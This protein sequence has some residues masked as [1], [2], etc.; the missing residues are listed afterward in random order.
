L[1]R[2]T[3]AKSYA[4]Q[5]KLLRSIDLEFEGSDFEFLEKNQVMHFFQIEEVLKK[6]LLS[7]GNIAY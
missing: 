4:D 6:R 5:I 7:K 1:Q 2:I 3:K